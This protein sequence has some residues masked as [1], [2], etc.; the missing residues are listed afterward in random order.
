MRT[1]RTARVATLVGLFLLAAPLLTGCT[2]TVVGAVGV[3]RGAD[4]SVEAILARCGS[5][6]DTIRV[7]RED[8][9]T[10][11]RIAE[12]RL[13]DVNSAVVIVN[14]DGSS[15]RK[16]ATRNPES[17]A[18]DPDQQYSLSGVSTDNKTTALAVTFGIHDV[19]KAR[20]G[21]VFYTAQDGSLASVAQ[22][23]FASR[24]CH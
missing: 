16:G 21:T 10:S 9:H 11:T 13:D 23:D 2:P 5:T 18:F 22:A 1:G 20:S 17:L 8:P 15:Q 12:L 24:V 3:M 7:T 19:Q 14:V 6:V 4:G